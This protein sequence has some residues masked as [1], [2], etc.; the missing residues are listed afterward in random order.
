MGLTLTSASDPNLSLAGPG[1]VEYLTVGG[2]QEVQGSI[3]TGNVIG[4]HAT[5]REEG[6]TCEGVF[7]PNP[8]LSL[9][10]CW[11]PVMKRYV[12]YLADRS[13][14]SAV[15]R[16]LSRLRR[17]HFGGRSRRSSGA[18]CFYHPAP[19][20]ASAGALIC[21]ARDRSLGGFLVA[22]RQC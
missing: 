11:Y 21:D 18:S 7:S 1:F 4:G 10:S 20:A 6:M 19:R 13:R 3:A 2:H 16:A 12:S 14:P 22:A 8:S 17:R 9:N 15:I 5:P